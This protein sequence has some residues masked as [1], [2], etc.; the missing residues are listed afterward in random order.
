MICT[1]RKSSG[2]LL[3]IGRT[4]AEKSAINTFLGGLQMRVV[5]TTEESRL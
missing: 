5:F 4:S 3:R 1:G 2:I